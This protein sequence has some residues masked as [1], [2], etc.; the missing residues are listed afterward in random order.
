MRKQILQEKLDEY[1]ADMR[2]DYQKELHVITRKEIE[3]KIRREFK[4]KL[5]DLNLLD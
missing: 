1:K 3:E 4:A 5:A 2:K